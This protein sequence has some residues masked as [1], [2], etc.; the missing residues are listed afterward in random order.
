MSKLFI[1]NLAFRVDDQALY[2]AFSPYGQITDHIVMKD[3][4]TGRPRGF[5]FVTYSSEEEAKQAIEKMNDRVEEEA[6][7]EA[8]A[9][10]L[11]VTAATVEEGE[12]TAAEE[13]TAVEVTATVEVEAAGENQGVF[14]SLS[15]KRA[16]ASACE[17]KIEACKLSMSCFS[18]APFLPRSLRSSSLFEAIMSN[19]K[20]YVGNLSWNTDDH[21][22]R[23]AFEEYGQV[24]DCIHMTDR[25]T[26]RFRGFGFVTFSSPAEAEAAIAGMNEKEL[27]GRRI[28]VNPA[29]EKPT[30]ASSTGGY[31]GG[32]G[33]GSGG[34]WNSG[35]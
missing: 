23:Q 16:I 17:V 4:E 24:T 11:E 12:A 31:G 32:N 22:L 33:G 2:N 25:E 3:R 7:E 29:G 6:V 1:G 28:R 18:S 9:E 26:G 34:G 27:G 8:T 35:W 14:F 30:R 5:G 21:A 20:L 15:S 10:V 19:S 13:A